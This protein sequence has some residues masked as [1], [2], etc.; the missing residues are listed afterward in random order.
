MNVFLVQ[1]PLQVLAAFEARE[2]FPGEPAQLIV[3]LSP[4]K[5]RN[6]TQILEAVSRTGWLH[7]LIIRP[8]RGRPLHNL[9]IKAALFLSLKRL[10]HQHVANLFMGDFR[11]IWMNRARGLCEPETT[12]LIDDGMVTPY[13][14]KHFFS[15]G[16]YWPVTRKQKLNN[17]VRSLVNRWHGSERLRD[18]PI[19][20][21]SVYDMPVPA[22]PGQR[23]VRHHYEHLRSL[24]SG[25][26]RSEHDLYFFGSK[27]SEV[28][29]ITRDTEID[30]LAQTLAWS[31][32]QQ[33]A[34]HY[35][36]H[37]EDHPDKLDRIRALDIPVKPLGMPAELYFVLSEQ[38]PAGIATF[39][40]SA[41]SSL[42]CIADFPLRCAF[43]IPETAI[44]ESSRDALALIYQGFDQTGVRLIR[45]ND[46]TP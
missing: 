9:R 5:T 46:N 10:A 34:L 39:C 20:V 44:R 17:L 22:A 18:T 25:Q 42:S 21:F 33:L 11:S 31:R 7:P 3:M 24:G 14:Q 12:W 40:S 32:A 8:Q 35:I 43:V 26:R 28:G 15:Q 29:I 16:I 1:S 19:S 27:L 36:P 30:L 45:M 6:N 13:V 38:I 41:M 4:N 37:R 2:T 23:V